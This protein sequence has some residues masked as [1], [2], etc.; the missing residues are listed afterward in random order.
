MYIYILYIYIYVYM[1]GVPKYSL[2]SPYYVTYMCVFRADHLALDNHLVCSS[3]PR[4][5]T[6]SSTP[7]FLQLHIV[8]Y[9]QLRPPVLFPIHLWHVH[10]SAHISACLILLNNCKIKILKVSSTGTK[11][12]KIMSNEKCKASV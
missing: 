11:K 1:W 10:C 6:T 2:L 4:W 8:F 7:R 5:I 12:H 3:T 9:V